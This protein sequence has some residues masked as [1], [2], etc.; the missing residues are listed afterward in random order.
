MKTSQAGNIVK[1]VCLFPP[2]IGSQ[3][4]NVIFNTMGRRVV[5]TQATIGFTS[6]PSFSSP[7]YL[8][9]QLNWRG[10]RNKTW[11]HKT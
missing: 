8:Y 6:S 4:W 11:K 5:P 1:E 2:Q 7:S 9:T 10:G 3:S